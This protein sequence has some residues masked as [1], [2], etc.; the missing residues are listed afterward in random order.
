MTD[1]IT[2]AGFVFVCHD[3]GQENISTCDV[4][5][6]ARRTDSNLIRNLFPAISDR[7]ASSLPDLRPMSNLHCAFWQVHESEVPR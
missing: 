1:L 5:A 6:H 7:T 4:F 2:L 3:R